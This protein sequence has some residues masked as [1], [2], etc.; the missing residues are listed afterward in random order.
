[1]CPDDDASGLFEGDSG[2]QDA[3]LPQCQNTGSDGNVVAVP[4]PPNGWT[5]SNW[6]DELRRKAERCESVNP[7]LAADYRAQADAMIGK[8][9]A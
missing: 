1:M 2:R 6:A 4:N 5:R 7:A 9:V 8:D 3:T